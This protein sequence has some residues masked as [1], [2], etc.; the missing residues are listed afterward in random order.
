MAVEYDR[1][2]GP[3][4]VVVGTYAM[5][6]GLVALLGY[7]AKRAIDARGSVPRAEYPRL[8]RDLAT[9]VTRRSAA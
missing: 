7:T 9:D 6:A 2:V 5:V 4:I 1:P 8:A 3:W